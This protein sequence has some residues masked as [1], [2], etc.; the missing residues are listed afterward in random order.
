MIYTVG[1]SNHTWQRFADL[2]KS[3]GISSLIDVRSFARSRWPQFNGPV[4]RQRLC[5]AGIEYAHWPCW[6]GKHQDGSAI[7]MEAAQSP[8]FQEHLAR[9]EAM[10][11][12][13]RP[14]ALMCAEHEPRRCH[15][16]SLSSMLVSRGMAVSHILREG[17]AV[18]HA[19]YLEV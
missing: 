2:L 3:V 5:E 18:P 4:L 16:L 1:H 12:K 9:L 8:V 19:R 11:A 17:G 13:G 15:R 7:N 14:V 10:D 6:G